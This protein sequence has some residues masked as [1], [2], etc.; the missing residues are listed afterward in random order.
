[1]QIKQ[2]KTMKQE[3]TALKVIAIPAP[4]AL[5]A[6]SLEHDRTNKTRPKHSP[7]R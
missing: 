2:K 1:M 4:I 6:L 7:L 3:K 5:Q